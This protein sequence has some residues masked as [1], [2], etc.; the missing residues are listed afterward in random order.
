MKITKISTLASVALA[1]LTFSHATSAAVE[2]NFGVTSNYLWRGVTQ[3]SNEPSVSGG[4]D[5]SHESGFYAGTW[6]GSIDW[7]NG[8]GT[9]N[10]Y[11]L[12]FSGAS[13]DFGYDVGYIYYAYPASGYEDSDFGEVYFNGSYMNFGFGLYYTVNSDVPDESLFDQGDMYYYAS[14]GFDLPEEFALGLTYG[15]YD[16]DYGSDGDYGHIQV[17]LSKGDFTLSISKAD[18]E[19]GDDDT[20]FV[21]SW[22][23]TF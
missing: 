9:E 14:Y 15:Y 8:G 16:F 22:G 12:G 17:D 13:G 6:I 21:V 20:K 3:S 23:T 11:Y 5:Y 10:D 2:A 1:A 7:G 4:L 18:E 19:A